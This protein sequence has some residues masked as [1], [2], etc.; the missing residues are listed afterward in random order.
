[1]KFEFSKS[2]DAIR[3]LLAPLFGKVSGN[4]TA[5]SELEKRVSILEE[6]KNE[7]ESSI[8]TLISNAQSEVDAIKIRLS[9]LSNSNSEVLG[10]ISQIEDRLNKLD[11]GTPPSI[12]IDSAAFTGSYEE[13]LAQKVSISWTGEV[14]TV[15]MSVPGVIEWVQHDISASVKNIDLQFVNPGPSVSVQ[16]TITLLSVSGETVSAT[17]S[18]YNPT[19]TPN[20]KESWVE[21]ANKGSLLEGT[22]GYLEAFVYLDGNLVSD[23]S[24]NLQV[25][26]ELENG[27][28][29]LE[30]NYK[31]E[32]WPPIPKGAT[33]L[34]GT[35]TVTRPDGST[36]S[37][38]FSMP[39]EKQETPWHGLDKYDTII[40]QNDGAK[41]DPDDIASIIPQALY[42]VMKGIL[43]KFHIFF[44]VNVNQKDNPEHLSALV[45]SADFAANQGVS[46]HNLSS[47]DG[48]ADEM[49]YHTQL[50]SSGKVLVLAG[51]P[52]AV[53]YASLADTPV[54]QHQNITVVSHA[55]WNNDQDKVDPEVTDAIAAK[56]W[57]DLK[58]DFPDVRYVDIP[59]QNGYGDAS[60]GFNNI[61]WREMASSSAEV[62]KQGYGLMLGANLEGQFQDKDRDASDFGML[63]AADTGLYDGKPSDVLPF[64]EQFF[65]E[66]VTGDPTLPSFNKV[67]T[68]TYR[69]KMEELAPQNPAVWYREYVGQQAD[70]SETYVTFLGADSF[71]K[72]QASTKVCATIT[73]TKSGTYRVLAFNKSGTSTNTSD[74]ND[75]WVRINSPEFYAQKGGTGRTYA[76][77]NASGKAPV[78]EKNDSSEGAFKLYTNA[79]GKWGTESYVADGMQKD[80]MVDLVGGTTYTFEVSGRSKGHSIHSFFLKHVSQ[81]DKVIA[82]H[83][84]TVTG[85]DNGGG[86]TPP[87]ESG[88]AMFDNF[89]KNASGSWYNWKA[90]D[91]QPG[92]KNSDFLKQ[93]YNAGDAKMGS[94]GNRVHVDDITLGG[95][96]IRTLNIAADSSSDGYSQRMSV[97][98]DRK[99]PPVDGA[100][101]TEIEF[102]TL[103]GPKTG[104][105]DD[106]RKTLVKNFHFKGGSL[107]GTKIPGPGLNPSGA[108]SPKLGQKFWE[109]VLFSGYGPTAMSRDSK[110]DV[111]VTQRGKRSSFNE[112]STLGQMQVNWNSSAFNERFFAMNLG[113]YSAS[114]YT[115]NYQE[116]IYPCL[117][118]PDGTLSF[119]RFLFEVGERYTMRIY[120]KPNTFTDGQYNADGQM[121]YWLQTDKVN[122]GEPWL[123]AYLDNWVFT[124]EEDPGAKIADGG[125]GIFINPGD[126]KQLEGYH[127]IKQ[128]LWY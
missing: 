17:M 1:M 58:S 82:P 56:T 71:D 26:F 10:R 113:L 50:L 2:W 87:G 34:T 46:V 33:D 97:P 120:M 45:A 49:L 55:V 116:Q 18:A 91:L 109:L 3:D 9:E 20:I 94:P 43:N 21:V 81:P 23:N 15:K 54:S 27:Y 124:T 7:F 128:S 28:S 96:T 85:D 127:F 117:P 41:E 78:T 114:S 84:P 69:I 37:S 68:D 106:D 31:Y 39:V 59:D 42:A 76:K 13:L 61:G 36:F 32:S 89:V 52:M 8:T 112:R 44:G 16:P 19:P 22:T 60:K 103:P 90:E 35:V 99:Y 95:E 70:L 108:N 29:N 121:F 83:L 107:R 118:N 64:F 24:K 110:G 102:M 4:E 125:I 48:F 30:N 126:S 101:A 47:D 73:P 12:I 75:T 72:W 5:I 100:V 88:I 111:H 62:I 93:I 115:Y 53:M 40:F 104:N 123:C 65:A 57:S 98:K 51:G 122:N 11:D 77:G 92:Q 6:S 80:L 66:P 105:F 67:S 119:D 38:I 74:L 79:G 86:S 14:D 63:Y 25:K